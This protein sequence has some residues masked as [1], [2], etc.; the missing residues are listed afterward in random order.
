MTNYIP[1]NTPT[2][3]LHIHEDRRGPSTVQEVL[4]AWLHNAGVGVGVMAVL[5]GLRLLIQFA[6]VRMGMA[7]RPWPADGWL[8][9]GIA[10]CL[11]LVAFG[12]IMALR[13]SLDELVEYG[14]WASMQGDLDALTE[15]NELLR[16]QVA[17]ARQDAEAYRL[18]VQQARTAANRAFV[19]PADTDDGRAYQDAKTL[20]DRH[21]GGLA[22]TRDE[23]AKVAGWTTS[24][25]YKARDLLIAAD[26]V[27]DDRQRRKTVMQVG[28][29]DLALSMLRRY[30]EAG[31]AS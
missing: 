1:A 15:E 20:V 5:F 21:F 18:E 23:M 4:A 14:E 9:L 22:W 30:V 13:G 16:A 6:A 25:W 12:V 28:N 3:T 26:V 11:G 8:W 24:R 2:E 17:A 29:P 31:S 19:E 27:A 7:S 10:A